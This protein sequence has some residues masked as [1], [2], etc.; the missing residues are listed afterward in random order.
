MEIASAAKR[1]I[2]SRNL[3][4]DDIYELIQGAKDI[5]IITGYY[6]DKHYSQYIDKLKE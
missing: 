3:I 1:L 6:S 4:R 2:H 5:E